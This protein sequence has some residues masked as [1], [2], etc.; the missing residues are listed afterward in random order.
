M[1][2]IPVEIGNL[3]LLQELGKWEIGIGFLTNLTYLDVSHCRL[4]KWPLYIEECQQLIYL[5]LSFN[6]I[7]E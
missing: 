4:M 6:Q 1:K 5:D 7:E 2:E 3:E